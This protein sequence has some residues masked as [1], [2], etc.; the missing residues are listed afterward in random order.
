MRNRLPFIILT[1]CIFLMNTV[2]SSAAIN[3]IERN[4]DIAQTIVHSTATG[5]GEVL[6]N[7][8]NEK[9]RI[10]LI[11]S[12]VDPIRFYPDKSGYFYVYDYDC[13]NIAHA[14]QKE[15][16]GKNL[17][18]YRDCKGKFVI[19]ELAEAARKGGGFVEYYWAKPGLKGEHKKIG[20]VE[21]IPN[22]EYF[23][24]T[25]VYLAEMTLGETLVR[26]LWAD[27]K[28]RRIEAVQEKIADG[29]Q[30]VHQYGASNRE[31]E[32]ELVKGLNLGE[33][34][35]SNF[36]ITQNGPVIIATYFVSVEETIKGKRL[37]KNPAPRLSVF[38]KT[39]GGWQWIA[40][41]NLKPLEQREK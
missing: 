7:I 8:K 10:H 16:V 40:H 1:S 13:V 14:T 34:T 25:G 41:A 29:F 12:F 4:K 27:L 24:G 3:N 36:Q 35:L 11:R 9:D 15:L 19:R 23:I 38:L 31:Q 37:S 2:S 28:D 33:Y 17:Y 6:K 20:Y 30:S 39:E 21:P 18:D 32:I 5:L 22:T 26:Q